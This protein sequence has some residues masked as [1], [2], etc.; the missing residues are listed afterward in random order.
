MVITC[1][2]PGCDRAPM[3]SSGG[4]VYTRCWDCISAALTSAF[5]PISWHERARAH[6]LP[7]LVVGGVPIDSH[8]DIPVSAERVDFPR[9]SASRADRGAGMATQPA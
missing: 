5:A 8:P 3:A 1:A 4:W 6:T 7:P 2:V 9:S